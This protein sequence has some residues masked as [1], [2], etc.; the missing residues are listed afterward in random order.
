MTPTRP[1][2]DLPYRSGVPLAI[3]DHHEVFLGSTNDGHTFAVLNSDKR[4]YLGAAHRVLTKAGFAPVDHRGRIVYLL[5]PTNALHQAEQAMYE[6]CAHTADM[7]DLAW[8]ARPRHAD[9]QVRIFFTGNKVSIVTDSSRA[10]AALRQLGTVNENADGDF[11]LSD[12]LTEREKV[13]AAVRIDLRLDRQNITSHIDL[14]IATP[15]AIPPAPHRLSP[16]ASPF[17]AA[18]RR[19]R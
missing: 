8:T 14:G 2:T 16:V 3:T 4:R 6:L 19:K 18:A 12:S 5:P 7:A 10:R 1:N 13:R 9:P 11:A 17:S 15:A